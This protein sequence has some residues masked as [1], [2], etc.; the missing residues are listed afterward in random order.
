MAK[1][2][3]LSPSPRPYHCHYQITETFAQNTYNNNKIVERK[4]LFP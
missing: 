3:E 2:A 4:I 1:K